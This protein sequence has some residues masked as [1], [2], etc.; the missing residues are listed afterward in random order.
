MWFKEQFIID[1]QNNKLL[2]FNKILI[3]KYPNV[4]AK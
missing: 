2:E 1:Q 3:N 4:F